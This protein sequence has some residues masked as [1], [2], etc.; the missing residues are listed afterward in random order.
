M[1]ADCAY[2]SYRGKLEIIRN[3]STLLTIYKTDSTEM[4]LYAAHFIGFTVDWNDGNAA[5]KEYHDKDKIITMLFSKGLLTG[6]LII[7][8]HSRAYSINRFTGRDSLEKVK[9]LNIIPKKTARRQNK[10]LVYLFELWATRSEVESGWGSFPM[11]ELT[12]EAEQTRPRSTNLTN[13]RIKCFQY[14]GLQY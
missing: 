3:D 4:H 6:D 2:P 14:I 5:I 1:E 10:K 12:I 9:I 11:F 13:P 8:E 7:N